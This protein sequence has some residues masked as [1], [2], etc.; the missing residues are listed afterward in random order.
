[1]R[2]PL[3]SKRIGRCCRNLA[4]RYGGG[5]FAEHT[6]VVFSLSTKRL[7]Q[8]VRDLRIEGCG[9]IVLEHVTLSVGAR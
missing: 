5:E 4:A 1:M 7:S 6:Q 8:T 2:V 3:Q 9:S